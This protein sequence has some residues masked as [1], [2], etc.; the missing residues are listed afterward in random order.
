M[1]NITTSRDL[2]LLGAGEGADDATNTILQGTGG[3][4]VVR[5]ESPTTLQNV[6]LRDLRITGGDASHHYG[7][8]VYY[9]GDV[10]TMTDCTVTGNAAKFGGGGIIIAFGLAVVLTRC[11]IT[12][13]QATDGIGGGIATAG[14]TTLTDCVVAGNTAANLG[15]GIYVYGGSLTLNTTRVGGPTPTEANHANG[16]GGTP[17][18]GIYLF[19]AVVNPTNASVVCGNVPDQCGPASFSDP[20]CQTTCPPP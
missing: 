8:G 1:G 7:G 11:T 15:G 6:T 19:G 3:T 14:Q 4:S 10:L 9:L 2:T 16:P 20:A 17:G 12:N 13:N 5:I 18:G